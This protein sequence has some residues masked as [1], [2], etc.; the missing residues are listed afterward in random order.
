MSEMAIYRQLNATVAF[1][2]SHVLVGTQSG[3]QNQNW[4]FKASD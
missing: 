1:T 4:C 3:N 2:L